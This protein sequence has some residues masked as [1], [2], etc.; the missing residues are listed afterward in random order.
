MSTYTISHIKLHDGSEYDV[1][2]SYY[3]DTGKPVEFNPGNN[4]ISLFDKHP[5]IKEEFDALVKALVEAHTGSPS[6]ALKKRELIQ[7][8]SQG[9]KYGEADTLK[10]HDIVL[11]DEQKT[12]FE[13]NYHQ[14]Y[15]KVDELWNK[16][17]DLLVQNYNHYKAAQNEAIVEI[18]ATLKQP[19]ST[20]TTIDL[21]V[22]PPSSNTTPIPEKPPE[23]EGED[24]NT[25]TTIEIQ[26][27]PVSE[28]FLETQKAF[29]EENGT[30]IE[31]SEDSDDQSIFDI[32]IESEDESATAT[33]SST[34]S[35]E[36]PETL[37]EL[38]EKFDRKDI[39]DAR[40]TFIDIHLETT[41]LKG[42]KSLN[43]K[44]FNKKALETFIETI[45]N[46]TKDHG[47]GATLNEIANQFKE[48]QA[49]INSKKTSFSDKT[50]ELETL[51][52][53]IAK[54]LRTKAYNV[55]LEYGTA[56][57]TN[58]TLVDGAWALFDK[59]FNKT[60]E[61]GKLSEIA[62]TKVYFKSTIGKKA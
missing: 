49:E 36:L 37:G 16:A 41:K 7:L 8:N 25:N 14:S 52:K 48:I 29:I 17:A 57:K 56:N 23:E 58:D 15:K 39:D 51:E 40:R 10:T 3:D 24:N 2:V 54:E 44:A 33:A 21:N 47:I 53:D 9:I 26:T 45:N 61:I 27:D 30:L 38:P 11:K 62:Y 34:S 5:K 50:N 59:L 32:T 18:P 46:K 6:E 43:V 12:F 13:Q 55:L 4:S 20:T 31:D 35:G 28:G 42:N 19:S 60:T 1:N 22:T